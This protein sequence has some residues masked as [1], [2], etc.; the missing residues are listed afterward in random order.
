MTRF[1]GPAS[2]TDVATGTG[3]A[4]IELA[5]GATLALSTST[6]LYGEIGTVGAAGGHARHSGGLNGAVGL[7]M[8]W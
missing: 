1:T 5:A 7:R 6:S 2:A 4:S 8:R 3:G